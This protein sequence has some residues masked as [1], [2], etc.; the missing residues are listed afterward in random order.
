[1]STPQGPGPQPP[2]G[3]PAEQP[4]EQPVWGQQPA[5]GWGQAQP[6]AQQGAQ[7][8]TPGFDPDQTQSVDPRAW[9]QQAQQG[10]VDQTQAVWGQQGQQQTP[11]QQTPQ[12]QPNPQQWGQQ[13]PYQAP[14]YPGQQYQGEEYQQAPTT[15]PWQQQPPAPPQPTTQSPQ[16]S[17]QQ[18]TQQLGGQQP[19]WGQQPAQQQSP[20]AWG[21]QQQGWGG[22][23]AQQQQQHQATQQWPGHQPPPGQQSP[24]A[25]GQQ[26]AQGFPPPGAPSSRSGGKSKLP[27][28]IGGAV[29][30]VAVIV[31]VLGFI[32]P[33]F[34]VTRVFD[35]AALQTGVQQVLSNDYK[36]TA[37]AVSCGASVKV[38]AGTKFEC[39]ATVDGQELT[40]PVMITTNAGNYE[41]GRPQ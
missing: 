36:V 30:L 20:P 24:P 25:W 9:S 18:P 13:L 28:I 8:P 11:Q 3:N 31:G 6:D 33:G 37:T 39:K 12:P 23:Q 10:G 27:L 34:F 14:Q 17:P 1:M 35:Q 2:H 32:A 15:N 29:V 40:V 38:E 5:G 26:G 4:A 41:V 7:Q 16:Q 21:E 22:Q 19:I